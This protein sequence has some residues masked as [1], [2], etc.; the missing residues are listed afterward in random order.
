MQHLL[1]LHGAIG[2]K[3]QFDPL[4][5]KLKENYT[6]HTL[7]FSGHGGAEMPEN[8]RIEL[9]ASE[10][11]EYLTKNNLNNINIFG[12]SM[13]GYVALYIAKQH[14]EKM[15]RIFTLATKFEWNAEIAI[16]ETKMLNA[17]KIAQKIPAFAEALKKRHF[18]NDWIAIL[19]KTA[20]MMV[21]MGNNNPIH[22]EDFRTISV[23]VRIAIGD[24]DVMVNLEE[25]I[26]VYRKLPN[27]SLTVFPAT[28]HPIEKLNLNQLA[29]ELRMFFN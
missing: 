19:Q 18:P 24:Q 16:N 29:F 14:P 9:F 12:Y 6:I 4:I 1:L 27:A 15:G 11:L 8:F 7:N 2:A 13:G 10:V 25:T 21:A 22:L 26:A 20:E 23:P 28:S 5:E 17:S 3:S